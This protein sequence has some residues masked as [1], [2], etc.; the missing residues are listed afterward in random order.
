MVK[1]PFSFVLCGAFLVGFVAFLYDAWSN[2]M[3]HIDTNHAIEYPWTG[4]GYEPG[5]SLTFYSVMMGTHGDTKSLAKISKRLQE[6]GHKVRFA[7]HEDHRQSIEQHGI[8]VYA[9]EGYPPVDMVATVPDGTVWSLISGVFGS[10]LSWMQWYDEM[11]H[12]AYDGLQEPWEDGSPFQPDV[13]LTTWP[14][15]NP[16]LEVAEAARLPLFVNAMHPIL[17]DDAFPCPLS[18]LDTWNNTWDWFLEERMVNLVMYYSGMASACRTH[19]RLPPLHH[20]ELQSFSSTRKNLLRIPTFAAWSPALLPNPKEY[21]EN[22]VVTGYISDTR[23]HASLPNELEKYLDASLVLPIFVG[24]GSMTNMRLLQNALTSVASA[25]KNMNITRAVFQVNDISNEIVAD[26]IPPGVLVINKKFAHELLFK[27]VSGMVTHGGAG[28]VQA[29]L[30]AGV[31]CCVISFIMDQPVWGDIVTHRKLGAHVKSQDVTP[32]SAEICIE[33]VQLSEVIANAQ[34]V[35]EQ[36]RTE[37][38]P[39]EAAV[40]FIYSRLPAGPVNYR[41]YLRN[42][43]QNFRTSRHF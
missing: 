42:I 2:S 15:I 40:Q 39:V 19:L 36:M 5:K 13:I 28:T 38:D 27:R 33:T 29:A 9:I 24:F 25:F 16:A 12:T 30:A 4:E 43:L 18:A 20:A 34:A 21:H 35:A 1:P 3:S 26:S 8:T 14:N 17:P 41:E 32:M 22:H 6:Y 11:C 23:K 31:P 37:P 10:I 7:A